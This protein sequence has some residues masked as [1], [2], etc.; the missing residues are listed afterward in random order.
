MNPKKYSDRLAIDAQVIETR[1]EDALDALGGPD[2]LVLGKP[3]IEA[4]ATVIDD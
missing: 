1:H 2:E 3:V 4:V